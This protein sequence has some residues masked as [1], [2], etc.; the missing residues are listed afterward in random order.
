MAK[1][2]I[3]KQFASITKP[4]SGDTIHSKDNPHEMNDMEADYLESLQLGQKVRE[5]KK[6][7]APKEVK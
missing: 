2:N 7:E 1:F 4:N 6:T 3:D 5:S